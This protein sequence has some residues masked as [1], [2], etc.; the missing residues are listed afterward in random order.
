MKHPR[1]Q[2]RMFYDISVAWGARLVGMGIGKMRPLDLLHPTLVREPLL[3]EIHPCVPISYALV[4]DTGSSGACEKGTSHFP[5]PIF[6]PKRITNI[7]RDLMEL[8]NK[9]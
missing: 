3:R 2:E 8:I 6:G 4:S 7:I 5:F 1:E 9:W